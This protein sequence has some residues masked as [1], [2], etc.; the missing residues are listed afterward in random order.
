MHGPQLPSQSSVSCPTKQQISG[1]KCE[2]PGFF[3]LASTLFPP[4]LA[5]RITNL[6]LVPASLSSSTQAMTPSDAT[7]PV[8]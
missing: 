5:T 7:R 1:F 2:G 4:S 3:D 6:V 8:I